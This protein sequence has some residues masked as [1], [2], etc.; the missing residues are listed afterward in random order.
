MPLLDLVLYIF[1]DFI[2]IIIFNFIILHFDSVIFVIIIITII[3][4][5]KRDVNTNKGRVAQNKDKGRQKLVIA[6]VMIKIVLFE[7]QATVYNK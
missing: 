3:I 5:K 6:S 4:N 7:N 2:I 1:F